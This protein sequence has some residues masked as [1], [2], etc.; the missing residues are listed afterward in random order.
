MHAPTPPPVE[1]HCLAALGP[2]MLD[3]AGERTAGA[4][5]YF[6]PVE[7]TRFARERLMQRRYTVLDHMGFAV[8]DYDRRC[9]STRAVAPSRDEAA[10]SARGR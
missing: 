3:L 1:Q 2:K 10:A 7:H 4:H 9:W 8:R 6:V 5:T